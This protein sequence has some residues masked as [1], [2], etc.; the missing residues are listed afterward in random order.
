MR[1]RPWPNTL[2]LIL[3]P[4][5][6][7]CSRAD[8][9]GAARHETPPKTV[10]TEAVQQET[11]HRSVDVVG[12]LAALDEVTVSSQA[13]GIVRAVLADLGDAVHADQPLVELDREKLGYNLDQQK[14]AL[15]SALTKY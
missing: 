6:A 5:M 12:T 8:A 14:A 9:V 13:E 2:P 11:L 15:A 3:L 1:R 10:R 4:L 7:A